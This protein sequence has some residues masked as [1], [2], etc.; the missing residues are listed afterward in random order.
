[1]ILEDMIDGFAAGILSESTETGAILVP[2][3]IC[4]E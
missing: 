3:K 2:M 4:V 1:M